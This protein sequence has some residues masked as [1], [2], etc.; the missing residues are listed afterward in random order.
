MEQASRDGVDRMAQRANVSSA[1]FF[2]RMVE[3]LE[4]ELTAEGLPFWW[5]SEPTLADEELP[6]NTD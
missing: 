3:H 1:V 6:I 4:T 2:E 5:P